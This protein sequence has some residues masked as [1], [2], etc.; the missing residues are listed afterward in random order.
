MQ[1][2]FV[3]PSALPSRTRS[4]VAQAFGGAGKC[5]GD[6]GDNFIGDAKK[7]SRRPFANNFSYFR[8]D[9]GFLRSKRQRLP[10]K[11]ERTRMRAAVR[12]WG[13]HHGRTSEIAPPDGVMKVIDHE[14]RLCE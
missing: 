11:G 9:L 2:L 10:E 1:L 13:T 7:H 12:A 4:G 14:L 3:T 8:A 5:G 6:L